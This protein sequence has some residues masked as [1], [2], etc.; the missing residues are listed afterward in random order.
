MIDVKEV[1][2]KAKAEIAEQ[3]TKIAVNRL[4]ELYEKLEK[5]QLVTRNIQREIDSY[6]ADIKDMTTYESAGVDVKPVK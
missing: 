6:L 5:S 3:A 4:K 1:Q 2:K